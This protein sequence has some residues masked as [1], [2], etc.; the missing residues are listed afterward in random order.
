MN[1]RKKVLVLGSPLDYVDKQYL[2]DFQKKYQ[3]DVRISDSMDA[4]RASD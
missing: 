4:S 2:E 3:L 1:A